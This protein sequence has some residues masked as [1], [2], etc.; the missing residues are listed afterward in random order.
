MRPTPAIDRS[1]RVAGGFTLIELLVVISII[2]ILAGMLLPAIN[3][4]REMANRS[5]CANNQ[6][7]ILLAMTVYKVDNS[8]LW[9]VRPTIQGGA[10]QANAEGAYTALGSLEYLASYTG[11][12]L[13]PASFA[14]RSNPSAKP[15]APAATTLGYSTGTA[16]WAAALTGSSYAYDFRI[17]TNAT[18]TRVVTADRPKANSATDGTSHRAVAIAAFADG[19]T[20]SI[21]RS[22]NIA[23]SGTATDAL[24]GGTLTLTTYVNRDATDDNLY[25]ANGDGWAAVANEQWATGSTS[26]A[27][28]R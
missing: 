21:N 24:G 10:Y 19:H 3:M 2:A 6:K 28:V 14:C 8:D 15:S 23:S 17:P 9:P 20:A 18:S 7:Q 22:P 26:R 1:A 16:G 4:V 13:G 27:W 25:D 12:D 5:A 11:G